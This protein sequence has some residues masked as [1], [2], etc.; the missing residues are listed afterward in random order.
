MQTEGTLPHWALLPLA[1]ALAA[2]QWPIMRRAAVVAAAE[3]TTCLPS[4]KG[5]GH[6]VRGTKVAVLTELDMVPV[7]AGVVLVVLVET[8]RHKPLRLDEGATVA[9]VCKTRLLARRYFT[10]AVAAVGST[11]TQVPQRVVAMA[12][13]GAAAM[14]ACRQTQREVLEL[15][16]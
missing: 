14:V 5:R 13:L 16:V 3:A 7:A 4:R 11:Q 12:G 6:L 9:T 2:K 1:A 8:P 15:T 10:P